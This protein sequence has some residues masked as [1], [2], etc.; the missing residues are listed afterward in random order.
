M[1]R[2]CAAAA[3]GATRATA[4]TAS[5]S[6]IGLGPRIPPLFAVSS[7]KVRRTSRKLAGAVVTVVQVLFRQFVDGD[8]GCASYLVGDAEAGVAVVV[9]P[10]YAIEQ[11]VEEAER[12]GVR[13]VET[14]ETHTHADHL[15]ARGRLAPDH[16]APVA[17][18]PAAEPAYPNRP[19]EDGQT[20]EV[21]SVRIRVVHTPGHRPEHCAFVVGDELALT[22]DSLFV[23]DAAR[24]DLAVEARTG[25]EG[26]FHS[27]RRL[28]ELPANVAVYPG[29]VAGSL[30]GRAMSSAPSSTIGAE[31]ATN[32]AFACTDLQDFV[33]TATSGSTP[34]PPNLERIVELNRGLFVGAPPAGPRLESADGATVLDVRPAR[35]FA[36]GHVPGALNVPV[37]GTSFATRAAFLLAPHERL[38]IHA[39]SDAE[40][41]HAVRSL[42]AVGFL[43]LAGYLVDPPTPARLDPIGLDELAALLADDA[44]D[45]IDVRELDERDLGYIPGSR[46]VP[47]RVLRRCGAA[48]IVNG[49]PVVTIC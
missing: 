5:V 16:G 34:R 11:Y 33:T 25:A 13:I 31:L 8:L 2:A 47:Y 20:L 46:H 37:S 44:V 18:H 23:G 43:D 21:G 15:A 9:D 28:A 48:E 41:D 45:L 12:S 42:R 26:L 39:G 4:P 38:A 40:R 32:A 35:A 30:C 7:E 14:L 10:A 3:P 49:K 19:L 6:R 27:L 24:P 1:A 29:H 36:A 17:V 22:G